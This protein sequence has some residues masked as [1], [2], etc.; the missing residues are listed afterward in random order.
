M[1]KVSSI[2]VD[3][4]VMCIANT[5]EDHCSPIPLSRDFIQCCDFGEVGLYENVFHKDDFR[6][7]TDNTG[8]STVIVKYETE[9]FNIEVE[10]E[11]VH[12]LQNLYYTI[13]GTEL[14]VKI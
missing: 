8:G 1:V 7:Y 3:A 5:P 12:Q 14:P 11:G 2:S 13:T 4:G 6:I 10:I 9:D